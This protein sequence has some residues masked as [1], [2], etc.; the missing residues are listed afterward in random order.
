MILSNVINDFIKKVSGFI[1]CN[2]LIPNEEDGVLVGLSG[3]ADSVA[4][5]DVLG[6][7]G[8]RLKAVHCNF[9][10]RGAE[11]ERDEKEAVRTAKA[12][13][14]EIEV[15]RFDVA[16][17]RRKTGESTEMACRSLRYDYFEKRRRELGLKWIAVGHHADDN[18]ETLMLNLLRGSGIRG[19]KGMVPRNG[20]IIRPF[21]EVRRS[22]IEAYLMERGLTWVNDSTNAANDYAR[23]RLRNII[24]PALEREFPGAEDAIGRSARYLAEDLSF[25]NEM[26]EAKS[27]EYSADGA[28]DIKR[29]SARERSAALLLF[30]WLSPLGFSRSTTDEILRRPEE[31]GREFVSRTGIRF[32]THRGLLIPAQESIEEARTVALDGY[33]FSYAR[34]PVSEFRPKPEPLTAWFDARIL[35]GVPKFELRGW[36]RGDRFRP[37][38]MKGTKKLSD[39]FSDAHLAVTE[40]ERVRVLTR[41][42]V[43]VWVI[44]FRQSADFA[45]TSETREFIELKIN[46]EAGL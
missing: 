21:L 37:F 27:E 10:L 6:Q 30:E 12:L 8:A 45:V 5:L 1:D 4:L 24:F 2:N 15:V 28:I 41:D 3:G 11:S 38:G 39:L 33:P 25:Y 18:A 35:E 14:V 23:N 32:V 16:A 42:G 36:R 7:L 29:L 43:I 13:A 20:H 44:G 22:E 31:S 26:V 34:K 46:L 17:R 9:G 40:K 19:A